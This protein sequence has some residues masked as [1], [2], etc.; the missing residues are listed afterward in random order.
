MIQAVML[1]A[2]SDLTNKANVL[3]PARGGFTDVSLHT[4]GH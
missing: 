1:D 2:L 4:G 3:T